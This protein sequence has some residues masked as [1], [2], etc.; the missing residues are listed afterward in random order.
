MGAPS[1]AE[2]ILAS[3]AD[4][5]SFGILFDRH[6]ATLHR[7]FVRRVG[8]N[9]ADALMGEAFRIAF[10]R[11]S[12][13][14]TSRPEARPWLYG[15]ATNL[16]ARHR[17]TEARRLKATTRLLARAGPEHDDP[18]QRASDAVAASRLLPDVV[19]AVQA[20]PDGERD[21]LLLH[22]WEELSYDEVAQ[23]L[24]LPIGTVRSRLHRARRRLRELDGFRGEQLTHAD[25]ITREKERFMSNITGTEAVPVEHRSRMYPRLAYRDELEALEYLT[26]VF[27]FTERRES[28]MGRGSDDDH[29]LAWLE[30]GDGL[31]M[32]GHVNEEVHGIHSPLDL[33]STTSMIN[34]E[35]DDI[36]S[37]Y[38]HAVAQGAEITMPIEDAYYG[39]RRYEAVDLEG[40][41]WHFDETFERIRARGGV[42]LGQPTAG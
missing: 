41:R 31:V 19:A 30:F 26:R 27:A 23:A 24:D 18:A 37:H 8:P 39:A 40:H 12:T 29:M 2:A 10:E 6:A 36:D 15:I 17:R 7:Y 16:V 35:V 34:V 11:R 42:V 38:A 5:S 4:P 25:V 14:D 3:S 13:Y 21:A 20:L 32:I 33:G 9:D 22:V 1:D 28:R